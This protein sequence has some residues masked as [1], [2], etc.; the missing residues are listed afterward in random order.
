VKEVLELLN[1]GHLIERRPATL[2]GG[3]KQRVALARALAIEPKLFLF[4]EPLSALDA[5]MREELRVELRRLLLSLKATSLYVTHDHIEALVLADVLAVISPTFAI[6]TEKNQNL[7]SCLLYPPDI[8]V[9]I[10]RFCL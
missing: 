5:A 3:E 4:D 6:R 10:L 1:V 9:R 7:A 2:S 8:T